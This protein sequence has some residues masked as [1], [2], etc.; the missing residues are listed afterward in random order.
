MKLS[1]STRGWTDLTWDEVVKCACEMGFSGIEIYNANRFQ[2]L[3]GIGSPFHKY[4]IMPTTRSL[5]EKHL[6]IPCLDSSNDISCDSQDV[7]D[8]V[9]KLIRLAVDVRTRYVCVFAK[10]DR[11]DIIVRNLEILVQSA[12]EAGVTILIKTSGVFSDTARL[13]KL[14]DEF[15]CDQLA[16]VWDV[17]HPYRDFGESPV[18]SI[19]NLGAYVKHVHLRDSDDNGAYQLVGEG[20][21]PVDNVMKAYQTALEQDY[22]FGPYGDALLI[23]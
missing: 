7:L 9:E 10:E 17:H 2:N 15:A 16:V 11:P 6:D 23:L 21:F 8:N 19:K 18:T 13:R 12:K 14:M 4:S 3:V 20:T 5:I 22:K 1:F